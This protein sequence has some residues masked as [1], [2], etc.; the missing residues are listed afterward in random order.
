MKVIGQ[1]R[2]VDKPDRF[3][4]IR[5]FMSRE[6]ALFGGATRD[7]EDLDGLI[8]DQR[9]E[10]GRSCPRVFQ[11]HRWNVDDASVAVA[12][13]TVGAGEFPHAVAAWGC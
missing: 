1:F 8:G 7:G 11:H 4:W 3:V 9:R 12:K 6:Q 2:D 5:A 10:D 13:R